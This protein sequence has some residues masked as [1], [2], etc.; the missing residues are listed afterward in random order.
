MFDIEMMPAREGDCLW[1]RYGEK[2]VNQIL[3]DSGRAATFK[4]L[5]TRLEALPKSRR[6]FELFVITHIDR[7]HI[8]GAISLLEDETLGIDFKEIWFNGYD[9]IKNLTVESF[10]AVQGE[11]LTQAL[12]KRKKRWNTSFINKAVTI[13]TKGLPEPIQLPGGMSLTLLS[14]DNKK[15][16]ELLP[17]WEKEC[18]A[19]G[20]VPGLEVVRKK[21][22]GVESFGGSINIEKLAATQ[23]TPDATKPNGTSIAF[24]AEYKGQRVVFAADAHVDRLVASLKHLQSGK[25]KIKLDAFKVSHHGSEGNVSKELLDLIDCKN[26]LVSTN[27]SYFQHPRAASMAR[28]L[29]FGGKKKK[30]HFNYKSSFTKIWDTPSFKSDFNYETNF[31]KALDNGSLVVS[32]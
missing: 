13:G 29:K 18:K 30:L 7:D 26:Y 10:G 17:T 21:I 24:L 14:P 4:V 6:I 2:K 32:L 5:K 22:K 19:A 20:I 15:L 1:I 3:I 11:R 27:G 31:P 16:T 12:L 9:Q 28:I 25:K 23:F 8:E